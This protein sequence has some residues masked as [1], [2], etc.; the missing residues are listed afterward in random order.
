MGLTLLLSIILPIVYI[1]K[2]V[3]EVKKGYYKTEHQER[4][5]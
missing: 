5:E 2:F 3:S 1:W 4:G